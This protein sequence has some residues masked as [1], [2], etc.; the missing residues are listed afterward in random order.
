M[1]YYRKNLSDR[2]YPHH[3]ARYQD[4]LRVLDDEKNAENPGNSRLDREEFISQAPLLRLPVGQ[5]CDWI[6]QNLP[7]PKTPQHDDYTAE[8]LQLLT[9]KGQ[10]Q[11]AAQHRFLLTTEI[12]HKTKEGWYL[13]FNTLTVRQQSYFRVFN[14]SSTEFKNYV[15]NF[16]R[17]ITE[18][19]TG[20]RNTTS[21]DQTEHC[22]SYCAVVEEGSRTGRLHIHVIH[23]CRTLPLGCVDPNT[24]LQ[25]P[26]LRELSKLKGLWSHGYSSPIAVRYSPIDAYGKIGWRWPLDKDGLPLQIKS[27]LATAGYMAKYIGKSYNSEKRSKLLWRVR[28]NH[29]HGQQLLLRMLETLSSEALTLLA[30]D[31]TIALKLNNEMIPPK[32]QRL[33]ALKTLHLR[34]HSSK[35]GAFT[36]ILTIA[37]KLTPRPSLLPS[38][39]ASIKTTHENSQQNIIHTMTAASLDADTYSNLREE[40]Y[41]AAYITDRQYFPRSTYTGGATTPRDHILATNTYAKQARGT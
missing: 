41:A 28:K 26:T 25:R 23:A 39:R 33:L 14:K 36:P 3:E 29:G 17:R 19:Y 1:D 21:G 7:P 6:F 15:R 5:V 27:P 32:L 10:A 13:I 2:I 31:S 16:E 22:H 24:G 35:N 12:A 18:A 11:R 20:T 9:E 8:L 4:V 40:C 34:D 38:S 37:K 30:T